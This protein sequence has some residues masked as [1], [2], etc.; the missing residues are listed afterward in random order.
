MP[1]ISLNKPTL[2]QAPAHVDTV[3]IEFS[4]EG[5]IFVAYTNPG[6]IVVL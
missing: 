3:T 2:V 5:F 6:V 4:P 1:F